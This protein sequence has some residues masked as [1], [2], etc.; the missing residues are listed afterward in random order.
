MFGTAFQL[1]VE[2]ADLV[3]YGWAGRRCAVPVAEVVWLE[4]RFGDPADSQWRGLGVV[5]CEERLLLRVDGEWR[6]ADVHAFG[7]VHGIPTMTDRNQWKHTDF[8][9]YRRPAAGYRHLRLTPRI[10]WKFA[11]IPLAVAPLP[12]AAVCYLGGFA[13]G[14]VGFLYGTYFLCASAAAALFHVG[15]KAAIRRRNWQT[16][17]AAPR[18]DVRERFEH[19]I[20]QA[21]APAYQRG[22]ALREGSG[23]VDEPRRPSRYRLAWL[24]DPAKQLDFRWSRQWNANRSLGNRRWGRRRKRAARRSR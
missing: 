11:T 1:R 15:I 18:I 17:Q 2:G 14:A 5:G 7:A 16:A 8:W 6:A 21:R 13:V 12:P 24:P 22:I 20:E 4:P 19:E 3:A 23:L 9:T 10:G